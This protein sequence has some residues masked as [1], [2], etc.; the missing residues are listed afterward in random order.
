MF[1]FFLFVVVCF[2]LELQDKVKT[3]DKFSENE[4]LDRKDSIACT[5]VGGGGGGGVWCCATVP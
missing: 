2:V 4:V 5:I 3:S 1:P